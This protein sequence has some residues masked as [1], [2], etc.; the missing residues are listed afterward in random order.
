MYV[1]LEDF[2]KGLKALLS[3]RAQRLAWLALGQRGSATIFF[4]R[5]RLQDLERVASDSGLT[6]EQT[7]S[8][9]D[10]VEDVL[11]AVA[12]DID[13]DQFARRRS[14]R[15]PAY[16]SAEPEDP[17][18]AR[19]KYQLVKE[20]LPLEA[21]RQRAWAKD[22]SK[23]N[24]FHALAWETVTKR[25]DSV[26]NRP[27]GEPQQ[28]GLVRV[29]TESTHGYFPEYPEVLMALDE[30]ELDYMLHMLSELRTEMV[31]SDA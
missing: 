6:F 19:A 29:M 11:G 5:R 18:R 27:T 24:L 3:M 4:A 14:G 2:E 13:I 9:A 8:I 22:T 30:E 7:R 17:E 1:S 23:I 31:D 28:I 21:L 26:L 20:A 16:P 10:D 25:D 12:A 15:R